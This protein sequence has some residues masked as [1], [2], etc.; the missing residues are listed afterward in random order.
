MS[1]RRKSGACPGKKKKNWFTNNYYLPEDFKLKNGAI[2]KQI[3]TDKVESRLGDTVLELT[4][5]NISTQKVESVNKRLKRSV[6]SSVTYRRNFS[7]RANRA[8]YSN[9][10]GP[11]TAVKELCEG[12]G[13]PIAPGSCVQ[14]SGK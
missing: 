7:G 12:F 14:E 6:S 2:S 8:V 11:V 13:C 5:Y 1:C 10:H 3:L 9:N 4:L